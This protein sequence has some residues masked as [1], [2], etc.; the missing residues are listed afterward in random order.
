[1]AVTKDSP[2]RENEGSISAFERQRNEDGEPPNGT[3]RRPSRQS[4]LV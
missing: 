2:G 4:G 3:R 1:M